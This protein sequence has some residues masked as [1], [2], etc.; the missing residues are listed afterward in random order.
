[1]HAVTLNLKPIHSTQWRRR[2]NVAGVFV[3][4]AFHSLTFIGLAQFLPLIREDLNISFTQAGVLSAAATLSYALGMVKDMT[5]SFAPGFLG[6][7]ALSITGA[8]PSVALAQVRH[9]ALA[10]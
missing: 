10:A 7:S 9:R 1:M 4:Q 2:V 3:C 5:G 6:I 8:V